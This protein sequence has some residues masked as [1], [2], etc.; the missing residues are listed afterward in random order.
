MNRYWDLEDKERAALSE[1][2]VRSLL[3][4]ELMEKGVLKVVAPVLREIEHVELPH[5]KMFVIKHGEYSYGELPIAFSSPEDA[6]RFVDLKPML[7]LSDWQ[8]KTTSACRLLS[9][10]ITTKDVVEEQHVM[11]AT[12]VLKSNVEKRDHNDRVEREWR[13][14][15]KLVDQATN[16]VW[17]DWYRC[18]ELQDKMRRVVETRDEYARLTNGDVALA[19]TFLEKVFSLDDIT[20]ADAWFAKE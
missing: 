6:Q 9:A 13:E 14:K 16:G 17:A 4:V 2:N 12:T 18:R 8:T 19:R 5:T 1:E 10:S 20:T 3:D 11:N 7:L 15:Q